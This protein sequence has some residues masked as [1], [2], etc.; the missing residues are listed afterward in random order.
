MLKGSKLEVIA[1]LIRDHISLSGINEYC[2]ETGVCKEDFIAI[3][4][5]DFEGNI[6]AVD[7]S[8]AVVCDWSVA[9]LNMIRAGYAV[10]RGTEWQK[11]VITY[12]DVFLADPMAY[13]NQFNLYL[14]GFF[15]LKALFLEE[16]EL[17]RLSAYFRELQEYVA[18]FDAI[19]EANP[20]DLILYDG[21]F[22]F[23]KSWPLG[24]VL[25]EIFKFA[26]KK[27]V[28]LLGISKSSSFYWGEGIS[29]P[30]VQHTSY[31]GS[32][33]VPGK[34]W[35]IGLKGK[36]VEPSTERWAGQIYVVRFA[37][38]SDCAFRVDAPF[39][40]AERIGDVLSKLVAYSCSA[41][42]LGY[43]HALF[44]AHHDIKITEQETGS[45]KM[46]LLDLLGERELTESQVRSLLM[47]SHD[48]LEMR[49]GR[50]LR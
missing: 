49:S 30:F 2:A 28:D 47:D 46:R 36:K 26:E 19:R 25:K 14:K 21:G 50:V 31:S 45:L 12:D 34:P 40:V 18:L 13:A 20:H 27:N 15:G 6:I 8:N 38:Q 7:G 22:A 35:Y 10:Y 32:Q 37:G 29:R 24:G 48:I 39:L 43:P 44:R 9:N 11:T 41:E 5:S 23:W 16:T 17:E 1:D 33:F 42:C 4:P 3:E